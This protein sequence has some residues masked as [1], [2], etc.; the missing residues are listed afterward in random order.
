MNHAD[1]PWRQDE[2]GYAEYLKHERLLFAW[3]LQ[4]FADTPAAEAQEAAGTFYEYEPASAPHRGLVFH[5]EAWHWAM[6]HI[7]GPFYW[8]SRPALELPS[9]EYRR[10]SDGLS[11]SSAT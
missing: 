3:C 1:N 5:D 8:I 7:F 4:T 10:V 9:A 2:T 11:E 6:L